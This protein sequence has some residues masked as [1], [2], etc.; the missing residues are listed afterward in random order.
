MV[1][2]LRYSLV[3]A[4]LLTLNAAGATPLNSLYAKS[5]V[6]RT[7]AGQKPIQE[8]AET[9]IK[10]G[11]MRMKMGT[12]VRIVDGRNQFLFKTDDPQRRL[13]V[14]PLPPDLKNV[15]T[16]LLLNRMI[17][18][19]PQWKR[20][21]IGSEKVLNYPTTL[22]QVETPGG[23]AKLKLW[24]T[25]QPGGSIPLKQAMS[26][27]SGSLSSEVISLQINPMLSDS[28][29]TAPAGYKKIAL[30]GKPSSGSKPSVP[31][32]GKK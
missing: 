27:A 13:Q 10:N 20:K 21:K 1:S 2:P 25:T 32:S 22:Y 9:W 18:A 15:S 4:A 29:F 3:C 5:R 28:L 8:M 6:T 17:G 7:M 31:K 30:P 14:T 19:P 16:A 12:L 23:A 26:D 24:I 11:K